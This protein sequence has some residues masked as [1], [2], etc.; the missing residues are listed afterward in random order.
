MSRL[1]WAWDSDSALELVWAWESDLVLVW[2]SES[3]LEGWEQESLLELD[4][5]SA[6]AS[7]SLAATK[8]GHSAVPIPPAKYGAEG[9]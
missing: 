9:T 6:R 7:H 2:E 3:A 5:V 8:Q 4:L 1:G